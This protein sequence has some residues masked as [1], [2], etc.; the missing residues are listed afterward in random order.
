MNAYP[1]HQFRQAAVVDAPD[2]DEEPQNA[3]ALIVDREFGWAR[4]CVVRAVDFYRDDAYRG[5]G[6]A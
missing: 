6:N 4:L 3:A 1:A 2:T 5:E